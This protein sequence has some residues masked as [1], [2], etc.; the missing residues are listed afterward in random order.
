MR[1]RATGQMSLR[2]GTCQHWVVRG[3]LCHKWE[4][5]LKRLASGAQSLPQSVPDGWWCLAHPQPPPLSPPTISCNDLFF[6]SSGV[7]KERWGLG[8]GG[9]VRPGVLARNSRGG[10]GVGAGPP[11]RCSA[12]LVPTGT[13]SH[14]C[15]DWRR[16]QEL[17][18]GLFGIRIKVG[19]LGDHVSGK[20]SQKNKTKSENTCGGGND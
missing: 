13:K 6:G 11:E 9:S 2:A 1:T 16:P 4:F 18:K 5:A 17:W 8:Q 14:E 10:H 7:W 15:S 19:R 20:P 12:A 3:C